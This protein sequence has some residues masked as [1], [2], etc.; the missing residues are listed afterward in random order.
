M[1]GRSQSVT[2]RNFLA[3]AANNSLAITPKSRQSL[4]RLEDG[5]RE[6]TL[7]TCIRP[8]L[9]LQDC[10]LKQLLSGRASTSTA[11]NR[12]NLN[13]AKERQHN[14]TQH[15]TPTARLRAAVDGAGEH[16]RYLTE[17]LRGEDFRPIFKRIK[18]GCYRVPYTPG[19]STTDT[20]RA[21]LGRVHRFSVR[22]S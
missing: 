2:R 6:V 10:S 15:N 14:T 3:W 21:R 22:H 9:R 17:L 20:T 11:C 8:G 4:N 19:A 18:V 1:L 12:P 13:R 16:R 5:T 7:E